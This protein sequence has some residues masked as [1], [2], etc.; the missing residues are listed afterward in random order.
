MGM[1]GIKAMRPSIWIVVSFSPMNT[2]QCGGT[3]THE[4]R[5]I[6]IKQRNYCD[7]KTPLWYVVD[8]GRRNF[9]SN[10]HALSNSW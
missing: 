7:T 9:R 6:V 3:L 8:L 4:C 10:I 5:V 1:S 2:T